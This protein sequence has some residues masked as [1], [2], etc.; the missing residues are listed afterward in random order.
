MHHTV[1]VKRGVGLY[2][3]MGVQYIL[4]LHYEASPVC[5]GD[6]FFLCV[7]IPVVIP[8]SMACCSIPLMD[9]RLR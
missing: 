1:V 8:T 3:V 2:Y 9:P 5:F 4:F 7:Y 6:L